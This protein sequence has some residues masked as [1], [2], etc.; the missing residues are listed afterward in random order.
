MNVA[1]VVT[2]IALA[3]CTQ[4]SNVG[5]PSIELLTKRDAAADARAALAEDDHRLLVLGGFVGEVPGVPNADAQPTRMIEGT[6]DATT[7]ACR[8]QRDVAEVYAT[9]YNRTIV[10]PH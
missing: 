4:Q 7:E 9:K 8:G 5:C 1:V 3:S 10:Q 2:F 6:S